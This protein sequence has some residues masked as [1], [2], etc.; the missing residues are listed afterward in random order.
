MKW[1]IYLILANI[2]EKYC[3]F[4]IEKKIVKWPVWSIICSICFGQPS[5][6]EEKAAT[7]TLLLNMKTVIF[8]VRGLKCWIFYARSKMYHQNWQC[9]ILFLSWWQFFIYGTSDN[10]E[11][12]NFTNLALV[13]KWRLFK[14]Y[15][16]I[17]IFK[18]NV[19]C[20]IKK[21]ICEY[22]IYKVLAL[23]TFVSILNWFLDMISCFHTL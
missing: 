21:L 17:N 4:F 19:Y 6:H 11:I 15:F 10:F 8:R 9:H 16:Y 2:Y 20:Y 5:C 22:L 23:N 1:Q 18:Y 13:Q 12:V 7:I 14:K 3:N